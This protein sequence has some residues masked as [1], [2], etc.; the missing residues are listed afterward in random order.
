[1]NCT[2]SQA[3]SVAR[4]RLAHCMLGPV[5]PGQEGSCI[6]FPVRSEA[7]GVFMSNSPSKDE[8]PCCFSPAHT[9]SNIPSNLKGS[10]HFSLMCTGNTPNCCSCT[11]L[12]TNKSHNNGKY[13]WALAY[14]KIFYKHDQCMKCI[15][16][17]SFYKEKKL[18]S[19]RLWNLPT[20]TKQVT[21]SSKGPNQASK[22]EFRPLLHPSFLF[23]APFFSS[24]SLLSSFPFLFPFFIPNSF[25]LRNNCYTRSWT[26]SK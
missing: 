7:Y 6:A 25:I 1:M 9:H 14:W 17:T 22:F 3:T 15:L 26:Y 23:L 13:F 2:S 12:W 10:S 5:D 21:N 11:C 20:S 16:L 18:R 24:F 8:H 19:Q 4:I